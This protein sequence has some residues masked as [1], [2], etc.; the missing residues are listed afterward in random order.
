MPADVADKN[1]FELS[2]S[3]LKHI[4]FNNR[5]KKNIYFFSNKSFHLIMADSFFIPNGSLYNHKN[6]ELHC[7]LQT[8]QHKVSFLYE[9]IEVNWDNLCG[10]IY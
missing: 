9:K 1:K 2:T 4:I 10:R 8:V 6:F 7:T 3:N 5:K